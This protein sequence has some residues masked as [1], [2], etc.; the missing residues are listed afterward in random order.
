MI[1]EIKAKSI[2]VASKLPDT[3]F[4]INAY[5]GCTFGCSYCYASFMGRF[6]GK[7]IDDWG[8]YVFPKVN[9]EEVLDGELSK[10]KDKTKAIFLSSVTDPYQG[11]ETKYQLTKKA[12]ELLLKHHWT[13]EISILTKSPLVTRDIELFKKFPNIEVGLTITSTDD[14]VSRILEQS[15]PPASLRLK[16]LKELN[17]AGI[18]TYAFIGPLLPHFSATPEKLKDIFDSVWETGTREIYMEHLNLSPYIKVRLFEKLSNVDRAILE[19]FYEAGTDK[20]KKE[21]ED[22]ISNLLKSYDFRLRLNEVI[23]HR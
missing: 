17:Q 11:L 3:D 20:Y 12:L 5:T 1:T 19:K 23:S 15:A 7:S 16:A 4:V 2:L 18:K 21:L 10:I 13:G 8:S 14:S 9:L 6:N 22:V